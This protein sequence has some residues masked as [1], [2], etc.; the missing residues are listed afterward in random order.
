MGNMMRV[1]ACTFVIV[2]FRTSGT[3]AV[4]PAIAAMFARAR[5]NNRVD[6]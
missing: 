3:T 4:A 1:V 5:I 6:E 2:R